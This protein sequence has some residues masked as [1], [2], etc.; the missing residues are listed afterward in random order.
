M[1]APVGVAALAALLSGCFGAGSGLHVIASNETTVPVQVDVWVNQ[2][3]EGSWHRVETVGAHATLSLGAFH[4]PTHDN[5]TVVAQ[6]A[7][8]RIDRTM[9]IDQGYSAWTV[10]VRGDGL[11]ESLA[12]A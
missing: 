7:G 6:A 8:F 9:H 3:E 1:R 4:G 12:V 10:T 5:Y 2:T 11:A